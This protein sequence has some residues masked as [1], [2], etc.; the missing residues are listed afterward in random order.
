MAGVSWSGHGLHQIKEE[1]ELLDITDEMATASLPGLATMCIERF[2]AEQAL[3]E[4]QV[5]EDKDM[6][7]EFLVT[8]T[9]GN[10]EVQSELD[11]WKP[12]IEKE[13]DY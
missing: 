9:V 1:L 5:Q 10:Q 7:E 8:L 6:Q 13:S 2:N 11:L 12:A 3:R 4:L